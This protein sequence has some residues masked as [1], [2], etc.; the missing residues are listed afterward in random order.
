MSQKDEINFFLFTLQY[1]HCY[2]NMAQ[3]FFQA[4]IEMTFKKCTH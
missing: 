4:F 3:D 2:N 1:I